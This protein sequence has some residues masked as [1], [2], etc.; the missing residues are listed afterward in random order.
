MTGAHDSPIAVMREVTRTFATE[1]PP[2]TVLHEVNL[3]VRAGELIAL[4]GRS[5]AGK[6]TLLNLLA[7]I[8]RPTSGSVTLLGYDLAALDDDA[9][10]RLR[11]QHV[12]M[13]FQNAHLFPALTALENVEIPLRLTHASPALRSQRARDA[14]DLVGLSA[15]AQH[16]GPELSGGEQQRV[17]L[18]RAVV[19]APRLILADEP[20]GNLDSATGRIIVDLL[21][22]IAHSASIGIVVATHDAAIAGEADRVVEIADG[23]VSE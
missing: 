6:T 8:D 1:G 3:A 16:R 13:I 20:T 23:R 21:R 2:I 14:L 12:G 9:R 4:R 5:G 19:T 11:R 10:A 18:A 7:G 15:R 17:A 22:D